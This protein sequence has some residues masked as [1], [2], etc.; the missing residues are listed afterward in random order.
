M[1]KE[2][3][4]N[5]KAFIKLLKGQVKG[6]ESII[7]DLRGDCLDRTHLDDL[8]VKVLKPIPDFELETV[9][10]RDEELKFASPGNFSF[11]TKKINEPCDQICHGPVDAFFTQFVQ[12]LK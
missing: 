12:E 3:K 11:R 1:A 7:N 9:E 5:G 10:F 4:K 2:N 6:M 8:A